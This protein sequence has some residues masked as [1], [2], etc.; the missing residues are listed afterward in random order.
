MKTRPILLLEMLEQHEEIDRLV[1]RERE[2]DE[3]AATLLTVI[4]ESYSPADNPL[5]MIP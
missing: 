5:G 1:F 4:G 3:T 2:L